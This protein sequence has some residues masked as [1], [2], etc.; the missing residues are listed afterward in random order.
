MSN[1]EPDMTHPKI[2]GLLSANARKSIEL[3]I[4]EQLLTNPNYKQSGLDAEYWTPLHDKVFNLIH[5]PSPVGRIEYSK[6]DG[7]I[8]NLTVDTWNNDM[9]LQDGELLY[10]MRHDE[11]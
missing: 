10:V 1:N 5:A 3:R 4:I 11:L 2:Q 9:E 8:A 6:H 7:F